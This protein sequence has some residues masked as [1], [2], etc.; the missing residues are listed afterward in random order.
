MEGKQE[1]ISEL[2]KKTIDINQSEQERENRLKKI[3]E[4]QR[5]VR[6]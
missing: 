1:R 4:P 2:E 3:I 6:L 5:H